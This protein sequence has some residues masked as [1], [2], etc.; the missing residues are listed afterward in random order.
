MPEGIEKEDFENFNNRLRIKF[1]RNKVTNSFLT[2]K[3]RNA[4]TRKPEFF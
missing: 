2:G 1:K 4:S 3:K